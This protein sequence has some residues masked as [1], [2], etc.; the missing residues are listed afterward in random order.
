MI[1]IIDTQP[2]INNSIL[3]H[4]SAFLAQMFFVLTFVVHAQLDILNAIMFTCY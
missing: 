1:A 4:I 2:H 3:H